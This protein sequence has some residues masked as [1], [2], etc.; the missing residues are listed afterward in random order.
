MDEKLLNIPT[1]VTNGYLFHH[2][3]V[4][5][6]VKGYR[7]AWGVDYMYTIAK[8]DDGL[9]YIFRW[10]YHDELSDYDNCYWS[11]DCVSELS[12]LDYMVRSFQ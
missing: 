9:E 1:S 10:V 4:T 8:N 12:L 5:H 7:M 6:T 11:L 3:W 2:N